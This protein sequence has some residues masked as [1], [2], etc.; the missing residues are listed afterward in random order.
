MDAIT[1][2]ATPRTAGKAHARAARRNLEVPC[3][4][5][6]AGVEEN[7]L[8]Q[9]HELALRPLIY[10]AEKH[11]ADIVVDGTT[12]NAILK[13]VVMH[14][15][16]DRPFHADFVA[17]KRGEKLKMSIPLHFTGVAP[18]IKTGLVLS[19][20]RHEVEIEVLPKNIPGF[21][22][23]SLDGL[24]GVEDAIRVSDLVLPE[25]VEVLTTPDDVVVA[26][27]P[28]RTQADLEST[29]EAGAMGTP[30]A[31]ETDEEQSGE[32]EA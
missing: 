17:L 29:A 21:I 6:G 20:S 13:S 23:V 12:Y 9:V 2:Q 32:A 25:G 1:L 11:V 18:A 14:P 16:T 31:P 8:F 7:V 3:I 15:V 28:P 22:E 27:V 24:A 10:T 19:T 5:Y 30:P 4:L 26:V